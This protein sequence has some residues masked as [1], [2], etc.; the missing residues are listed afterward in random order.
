M[1]DELNAG[2]LVKHKL[3][4]RPMVVMWVELEKEAARCRWLDGTEWKDT[5]FRVDELELVELPL[6]RE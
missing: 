2:D 4:E 6:P 3:N 1:E 5:L